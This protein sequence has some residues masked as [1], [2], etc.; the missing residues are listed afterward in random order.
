MR[1]FKTKDELLEMFGITSPLLKEGI[2]LYIKSLIVGEKSILDEDSFIDSR[3][4]LLQSLPLYH[5][6]AKFNLYNNILSSFE[7]IKEQHEDFPLNIDKMKDILQLSTVANDIYYP[8][9]SCMFFDRFGGVLPFYEVGAIHVATIS[10]FTNALYSKK[11]RTDI[12]RLNEEVIKMLKSMHPVL[13]DD[14]LVNK[15]RREM[16]ALLEAEKTAIPIN[17]VINTCASE[18]LETLKLPTNSL[19]E[20]QSG[21]GSCISYKKGP[22]V[23]IKK[24]VSKM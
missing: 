15:K 9:V 5:D 16:E 10:I 7:K 3:V 12:Y 13:D 19:N 22:E 8:I 18:F 23:L 2:N 17:N 20:K 24:F 11:E 21:D 6:V 4:A 14:P 1:R